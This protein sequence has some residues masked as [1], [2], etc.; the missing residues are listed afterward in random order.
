MTRSQYLCPAC[1]IIDPKN[2][3]E[4][5]TNVFAAQMGRCSLN[6][7]NNAQQ[8]PGQVSHNNSLHFQHNP[9]T[10][11]LLHPALVVLIEDSTQYIPVSCCMQDRSFLTIL[12]Y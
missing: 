2:V 1:L 7:N 12:L 3:A 9:G 10:Q 4:H 8:S 6:N 5:A 11:L